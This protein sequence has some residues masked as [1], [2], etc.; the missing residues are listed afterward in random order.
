M[1]DVILKVRGLNVWMGEKHVLKDVKLDVHKNSVLAVMGPSG[2]GKSTLL[3]VLDRIIELNIEA[4]VS[5][6]AELDGKSIFSIDVH[7]LRRK[8][9]MVFQKPNP[10]PHMSIYDNIAYGV[11]MNG[12]MKKKELIDGVVESSL[13]KAYLWEEVKEELKKKASKLSGGQ[14]Q[15]LCIARALALNP[16]VLLMDEPTSMVDVVAARKIEELVVNLKEGVT[17]VIVTHNPLQAARISDYVAFLYD[18][19]MVEEG[20]TRDIFT[21]P[22]NELTEKYV[23]GKVV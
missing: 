10:F 8:V 2:S 14:Q 9:G 23:L 6:S 22:K 11:R 19:A 7:M 15:R 16:L 17:V 20:L 4:K 3:R 5:G 1:D 21:N 13:K 18:G 12:I